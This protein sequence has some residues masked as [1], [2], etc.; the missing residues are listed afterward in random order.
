MSL[1]QKFP[2]NLDLA[3]TMS[4]LSF[5]PNEFGHSMV[6]TIIVNCFKLNFREKYLIYLESIFMIVH[7][8]MK[9]MNS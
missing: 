4:Y 1:F 3:N 6:S 2:T 8:T 9:L 5:V 7:I